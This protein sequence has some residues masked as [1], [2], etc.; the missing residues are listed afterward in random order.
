VSTGARLYSR[1]H[2]R[3]RTHA[4]LLSAGSLKVEDYVERMKLRFEQ[5]L[6]LPSMVS[7]IVA[8]TSADA[9]AAIAIKGCLAGMPPAMA[10]AFKR[11]HLMPYIDEIM[12]RFKEA[13]ARAKS[14]SG[15]GGGS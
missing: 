9:V 15:G 3:A 12:P 2:T 10:D 6:T 7:V 13:A 8:D 4:L 1:T 11:D 5:W 14:A